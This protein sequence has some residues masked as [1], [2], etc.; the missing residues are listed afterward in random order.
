MRSNMQLNPGNKIGHWVTQTSR[1]IF[2]RTLGHRCPRK[3]LVNRDICILASSLVHVVH[4]N[5]VL[6]TIT[7]ANFTMFA[8]CEILNIWKYFIIVMPC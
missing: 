7:G 6:K 5:S 1:T 4:L 2:L 8:I 3:L